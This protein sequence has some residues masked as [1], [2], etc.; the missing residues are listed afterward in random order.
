MKFSNGTKRQHFISQVEQKLN[1]TSNNSNKIYSFTLM[2][3]E[4]YNLKLDDDKGV[5]IINN[6]RIIDLFSFDVINKNPER[7]NFEILFGKYEISIGESTK[8]LLDK[9]KNNNND[10]KNELINIFIL[11]IVNFARNPYSIKKVLNTFPSLLTMYPLD[12]ELKETFDKVLYGKKPQQQYLCN[13]LG[14]T[15]DVYRDWLTI[16]FML[17]T[18]LDYDCVNILEHAIKGLYESKDNAI[19]VNIYTY[20]DK[21][22]L[23]SDR[24]FSNPIQDCEH[25]AWDFNLFSHGFIQ[26]MFA[27][28]KCFT[29]KSTPEK[30]IEAMMRKPKELNVHTHHND[31]EQLAVYNKNVVYQCYEKVYNS[32]SEIY[33]L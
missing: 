19:L 9:I 30:Y 2:D 17:L 14:I 3:R 13:L 20:D 12:K 16:I 27:D 33:G 32:S 26:Y 22:C 10:I 23:L 8:R 29:P 24:G 31:Y 7:Y 4:K 18:P 5:S 25:M 21:C 15:D 1:S 11:K 28:W 6:L